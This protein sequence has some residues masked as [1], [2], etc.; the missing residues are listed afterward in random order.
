MLGLNQEQWKV[1]YQS[2]FAAT[3]PLAWVLSKKLG[4]STDDTKMWLDVIASLTPILATAWMAASR[5][6]KSQVQAVANM[7]DDK[8]STAVASLTIDDQAR[9]AASLSNKAVAAAVATMPA[10]VQ[11]RIADVMSDEVKIASVTALPDVT[12][13][14]V[15][16]NAS[17]GVG[18]ALADSNEPKVV[19]QSST[20]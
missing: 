15:K 17:N 13:I 8:K 4:L 9:I 5:T 18:K 1:I 10:D 20:S 19:P 11:I 16:D 2:L 7:S 6:E 12:H 14:V 3:G